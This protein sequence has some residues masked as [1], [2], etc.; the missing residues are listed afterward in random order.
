MSFLEP[1]GLY[2]GFMTLNPTSRLILA[3]QVCVVLCVILKLYYKADTLYIFSLKN[4]RRTLAQKKLGRVVSGI[5]AC[6]Q[7]FKVNI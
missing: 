5:S 6:R 3:V 7:N 4:E 2:P 1:I